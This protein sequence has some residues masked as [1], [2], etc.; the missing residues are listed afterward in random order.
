MASKVMDRQV[1]AAGQIIFREGKPGGAAYVV[2][3]GS[4]EI[5]KTSGSGEDVVLGHIEPGGLFG[6]LS[7]IDDAPRMASAR[8]RDRTVVIAISRRQFEYKL[9]ESDRFIRAI[10]RILLSNYRQITR[11]S[12]KL[13]ALLRKHGIPFED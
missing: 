13:E 3:E 9:N 1:F 12:V 8:A 5:Y 10:L 6:E 2:Q 4:V 11:R 7:L